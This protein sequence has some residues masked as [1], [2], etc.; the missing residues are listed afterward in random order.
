MEH[1]MNTKSA[2]QLIS[3]MQAAKTGF[4][5]HV[6]IIDENFN[7][8]DNVFVC[9]AQ[10]SAEELKEGYYGEIATYDTIEEAAKEF[11][12]CMHG[13]RVHGGKYSVGNLYTKLEDVQEELVID[14]GAAKIL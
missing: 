8:I 11:N 14:L 6:G 4:F 10:G 7:I 1:I 5:Q 13:L 3:E 9:S 12:I 2:I